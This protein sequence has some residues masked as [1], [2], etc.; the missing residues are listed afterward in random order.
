MLAK[1]R[2]YRLEAQSAHGKLAT[3]RVYKLGA[4]SSQSLSWCA[5]SKSCLQVRKPRS[6]SRPARVSVHACARICVIAPFLCVRTCACARAPVHARL[7]ARLRGRARKSSQCQAARLYEPVPPRLA[8]A[9]LFGGTGSMGDCRTSLKRT[10][11]KPYALS[12]KS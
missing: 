10:I 8:L 12:N 6:F 4:S 2:L 11:R 1:N 3:N 7:P 9:R 5:F